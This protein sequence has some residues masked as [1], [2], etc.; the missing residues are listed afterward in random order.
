[1]LIDFEKFPKVD[2][3]NMNDVH[4]NDIKIINEL[5]DLIE[6]YISNESEEL[7]S[8]LDEKY[9]EW[10]NHTIE[11]FSG[12]EKMM[13][14][15]KFPPYAVHKQEHDNVLNAM[16]NVQEDLRKTKS[17]AGVKNFVQNGLVRWLVNHVQT[18]DTVTARFLSGKISLAHPIN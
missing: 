14:E 3:E 8:K 9:E 17:A 2:M 4:E 16:K 1:M 12:E 13:I 10:L 7:F 6:N 15:K 18:M 5:N 11:H